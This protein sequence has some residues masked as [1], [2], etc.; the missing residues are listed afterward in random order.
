MRL[1]HNADVEALLLFSV[2]SVIITVMVVVMAASFDIAAACK[3]L[4]STS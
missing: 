2:L 1:N 4:R 3:S